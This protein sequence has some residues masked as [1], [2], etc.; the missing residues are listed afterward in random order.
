[1]NPAFPLP[2][3]HPLPATLAQWE[4]TT[5]AGDYFEEVKPTPLGYLIWSEFPIKVYLDQPINPNET[6][7][8]DRRFIQWVEAVMQAINEWNTYLPL[9]I[10]EDAET[11]DIVI[12]RSHP[13]MKATFNRETG[14]FDIPRARTAQTRYSFYLKKIPNSLPILSHKMTIQLSPNQSQANTLATARHELGHGLGIWGHSLDENDALYFSQVRNPPKISVRDVNTLKA[15][16][17][18]PTRLGWELQ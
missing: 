7:A 3:V 5:N 9:T 10:I 13:E 8:S 18:Q 16:Y 6:I 1:M 11:A 14:Q 15:I 4:D 17:Q 2:Q 12:K